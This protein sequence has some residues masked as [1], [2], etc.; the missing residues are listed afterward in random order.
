MNYIKRGS[1]TSSSEIGSKQHKLSVRHLEVV[2]KVSFYLALQLTFCLFSV[3]FLL[4]N[5]GLR[6]MREAI[7][8]GGMLLLVVVIVFVFVSDTMAFGAFLSSQITGV[9]VV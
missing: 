8:V 3:S 2:A 7:S 4:L 5:L 6:M 9:R 1:N